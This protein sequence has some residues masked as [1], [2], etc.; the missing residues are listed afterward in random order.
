MVITGVCVVGLLVDT[1]VVIVNWFP[2]PGIWLLCTPVWRLV[3][4][5][6]GSPQD[7]YIAV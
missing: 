7:M 4:E 2:I 6:P 1:L 3:E 5:T